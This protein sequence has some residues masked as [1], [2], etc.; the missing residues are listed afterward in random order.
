M[1]G[2]TVIQNGTPLTFTDSR[3]G[4]IY[5]VSGPISTTPTLSTV[6]FAPVNT[7][8]AQLCSGATY[9]SLTT[10]GGVSSRLGGA[11]GSPGYFNT[12]QFCPPPVI[13]N[14]TDYGDSGVGV[15][16]GPG[17]FNWDISIVKMT[18]MGEK[19]SLQFRTEFFNAFNHPQFNNPG[20]ADSTPTTF[21]V[22][23]GTS[24]NPRLIQF[25]LKFQF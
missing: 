9:G 21:G 6:T 11:S 17:Q 22:I 1:S 18:S 10:S 3:A 15:V 4:T 12:A 2:V 19:R 25:A 23:T 20:T 8:R 14:G 5:G 13:G 24:V 7:G 16:V